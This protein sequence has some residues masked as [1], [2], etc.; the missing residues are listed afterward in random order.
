MYYTVSARLKEETAAELL[1]KLNDGTIESQQP[2]GSE[3][4]A[5]M[6]RARVDGSGLIRWSEV[7]YCPTPLQHERATVYDHHFDDLSTEPT[8]GY[9]D[10]EGQKF[11]EYLARLA[12]QE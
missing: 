9:K 2:D 10:F 11:M 3:I 5:S 8:D 1:R 7:C 4:V 6:H 12:E